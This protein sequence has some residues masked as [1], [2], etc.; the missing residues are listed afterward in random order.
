MNLSKDKRIVMTLDAGG[1]NLVFSA[2]KGGKE[3]VTPIIKASD[4]INLEA[5]LQIIITGF[6][7]LKA[8]L[9]HAKPVAIS[10]AFPGPA[11]YKNGIIGDL[12]NFPAFRG[13]I[14]MG[15]MLQDIFGLPTFINNDGNLF[16]YGEAMGGF[17]PEINAQLRDKNINKN[18]KNLIGI[19]LGTGFGCG[20]VVNNQLCDGD[21]SAA[22]EIWLT[23]NYK[24]P[25]H[26]AEEGVSI[27]AIQK[28][29]SQLANTTQ[30]FSPKEIFDI[31]QGEK[32]GNSEAAIKAFEQTALVIAESLAHAL[33]LID[34]AV[35][36]GGGIS[37]ASQLILPHLL[38][39]LN[40]TIKNQDGDRIPRL[41]SKVF[42][43]EDEYQNQDFFE[44]NKKELSIPFKHEK[45]EYN[46]EKRIPIGISRLGTSQAI[47]LGAYAFA[48]ASLDNLN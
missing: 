24:N 6:Q 45:I 34:G 5:C 20:I 38:K 9:G 37:G 8:V 10:F 27:R 25:E 28:K 23:R 33:T 30:T 47:F 1:T 40:G 7:E 42:N 18:Y 14:P 15:P 21:N 44:W 22:G 13:G 41:L 12:P 36:I 19:T 16:A 11:D 31:A 3:L 17:L 39:H 48:L 43:L 2:I 46:S 29:Y 32:E 26:M 4:S 35:V